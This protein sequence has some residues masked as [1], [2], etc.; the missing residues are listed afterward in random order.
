MK[1]EEVE[2]VIDLT[3]E[4]QFAPI[5]I[6]LK[7]PSDCSVAVLHLWKY[8]MKTLDIHQVFYMVDQWAQVQSEREEVMKEIMTTLV[9]KYCPHYTFKV[10]NCNPEYQRLLKE[11]RE[12]VQ[13]SEEIKS[14]ITGKE[15]RD[16]VFG[17][18]R[19]E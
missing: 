10:D 12:M 7:R 11:H 5:N 17:G 18:R 9:H 6:H 16:N 8:A 4:T 1:K 15:E 19:R 13:L 14:D 2:Q 3:K